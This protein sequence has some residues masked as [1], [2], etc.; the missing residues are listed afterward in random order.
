MTNNTK[1]LKHLHR[2]A[3]GGSVS[4]KEYARQMANTRSTKA[5]KLAQG[6]LDRKGQSR[7]PAP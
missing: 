5:Q 6:W 2:E 1:H 4:L 3:T 7:V